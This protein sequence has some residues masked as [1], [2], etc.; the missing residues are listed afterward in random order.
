MLPKLNIC[1][2]IFLSESHG[3]SDFTLCKD[4]KADAHYKKYEWSFALEVSPD[5]IFFL[6][7]VDRLGRKKM[8]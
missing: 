7:K 3:I 8:G 1:Y 2:K 4:E 6:L 5:I